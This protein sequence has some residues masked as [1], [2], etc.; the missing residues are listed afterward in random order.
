MTIKELK[1]LIKYLPG[2]MEVFIPYGEDLI[3]ACATNSEV[4]EI[5]TEDDIKDIFI[6]VPCCCHEELEPETNPEL[7]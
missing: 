3:G 1:K 6:L 5:E 4:V 7:N 2:H